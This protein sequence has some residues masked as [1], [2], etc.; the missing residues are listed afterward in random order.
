MDGA[1]LEI[2][3]GEFIVIM[4]PSGSGK[5]SLLFLL[6]GLEKPDDGSVMYGET[7]VDSA[8][9]AELARLRREHFGFVFQG[10]HLIPYLTLRENIRIAALAGGAAG[11]EAD[12]QTDALLRRFSLESAAAGLPSRVSG[13]EAQRA[14]VARAIVNSPSLLFADEPTGALNRQAGKAILEALRELNAEGLS[15]VMVTHDLGAAAYGDRIVFM[16]DGALEGELRFTA[17]DD[18]EEERQKTR[19]LELAAWLAERGW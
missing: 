4:G 5:S 14:A 12:A 10:I 17:D 7:R 1:G 13:G 15:I 6:S 19:S 8:G 16:R 3:R 9:A 2:E 18:N 11:R